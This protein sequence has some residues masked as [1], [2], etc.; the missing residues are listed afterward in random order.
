MFYAEMQKNAVSCWNIKH[1]LKRSNMDTVA[2]NN[3][4]LIYP[5][6]LTVGSFV[7]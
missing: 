4:T 1:D 7:L 3:A 2:Q 5:V 6:D